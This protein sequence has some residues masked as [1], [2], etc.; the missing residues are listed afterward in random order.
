MKLEKK[1]KELMR[2]KREWAWK[3]YD[4]IRE[5]NEQGKER[6]TCLKKKMKNIGKNM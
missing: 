2:K 4:V 5:K 6:L 1:R 3:K